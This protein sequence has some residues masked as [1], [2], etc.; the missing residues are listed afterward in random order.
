MEFGLKALERLLVGLGVCSGWLPCAVNG[1]CC[2]DLD[3]AACAGFIGFGEC[4]R[5]TLLA[6][7]SGDPASRID[8]DFEFLPAPFGLDIQDRV[9]EVAGCSGFV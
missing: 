7:C 6:V 8:N 2:E 9:D 3:M 5:L 4:M 1:H